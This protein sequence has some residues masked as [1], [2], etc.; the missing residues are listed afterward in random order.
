[1]SKP[2]RRIVVALLEVYLD[3]RSNKWNLQL[4]DDKTLIVPNDSGIQDKLN[5][6]TRI[7]HALPNRK[8][9][10]DP[11]RYV[12][13]WMEFLKVLQAEAENACNNGVFQQQSQQTMWAIRS[14][15]FSA[16]QDEAAYDMRLADLTKKEVKTAD[17]A[18]E[19][20]AL[21]FDNNQKQYLTQFFNDVIKPYN[22]RSKTLQ[23]DTV[24]EFKYNALN[25]VKRPL[26]WVKALQKAHPKPVAVAV[27][28]DTVTV[29]PDAKMQAATT[30]ET[31]KLNDEFKDKVVVIEAKRALMGHSLFAKQAQPVVVQQEVQNHSRDL[32]RQAAK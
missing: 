32:R 10:N 1:M 13:K 17:E 21:T 23:E 18:L 30:T 5:S 26:K 28:V 22:Q 31:E 7:L 24:D 19:L 20:R 6:I 29:E 25:N 14:Y 8:I 15:I 9:K 27:N 16:L 12:P 4:T 11:V 2:N 3:I